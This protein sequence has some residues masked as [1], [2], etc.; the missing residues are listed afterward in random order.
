MYTDILR[1]IEGIGIFPVI[2]LLVFVT[3]F[4]AVLIWAIRADTTRLATLARLPLEGD[5]TEDTARGSK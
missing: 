1:S 2:S 4:S 3:V 5:D